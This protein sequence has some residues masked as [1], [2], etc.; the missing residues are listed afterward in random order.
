MHCTK[1]FSQNCTCMHIYH[2]LSKND[3]C[4]KRIKENYFCTFDVGSVTI[5]EKIRTIPLPRKL[6][7]QYR[8]LHACFDLF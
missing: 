2:A 8:K 3:I 1:L 7:K 4:K 5:Q 6:G